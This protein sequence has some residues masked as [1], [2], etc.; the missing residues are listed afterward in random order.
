MGPSVFHGALST[1]LAIIV[2][3]PSKSY[4]FQ[5][6]F[7]MWFGIIIHGVANGF[8]LLPVMLS[9]V[10]PLNV[11]QHHEVK[12][13]DNKVHDAEVVKVQALTEESGFKDE[14]L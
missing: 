10:G 8:I 5:M 1:F 11:V 7:R 13:S 14:L 12:S 9:L 4:I 6:F 2:L 3:S